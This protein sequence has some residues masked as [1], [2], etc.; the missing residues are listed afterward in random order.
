MKRK[1][2][3]EVTLSE[4]TRSEKRPGMILILGSQRKDSPTDILISDFW[5]LELSKD[6]FLLF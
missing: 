5:S 1:A 2:D 6:K 3:T 4:A